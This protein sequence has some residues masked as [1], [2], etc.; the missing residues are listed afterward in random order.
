MP[1]ETTRKSVKELLSTHPIRAKATGWFF[2][3]EDSP[4][5]VWSIDGTDPWGRS[6]TLTGNDKD[7]VLA[8]AEANAQRIND[9][10]NIS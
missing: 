3:L 6:V 8:R 7:D 4:T 1:L 10:L 9:G 5:G 2:R